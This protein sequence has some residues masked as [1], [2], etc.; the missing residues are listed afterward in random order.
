LSAGLLSILEAHPTTPTINPECRG[1]KAAANHLKAGILFLLKQQSSCDP[2]EHCTGDRN[3]GFSASVVT[4]KLT[5]WNV[6][7][8]LIF[9]LRSLSKN[10][11]RHWFKLVT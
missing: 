7:C 9:N 4:V 11:T 1:M 2:N 10:R 6:C 5:M 3:G 8:V